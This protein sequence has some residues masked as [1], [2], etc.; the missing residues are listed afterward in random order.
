LRRAAGV[1][2]GAGAARVPVLRGRGG[3]ALGRRG[4]Q[5]CL[6]LVGAEGSS[7]CLGLVAESDV[8]AD[9]AEGLSQDVAVD[10]D[11]S[12]SRWC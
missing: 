1:R 3:V 5:E 4:S 6:L 10:K 2:D 12:G 7:W 11:L 8:V 9:I